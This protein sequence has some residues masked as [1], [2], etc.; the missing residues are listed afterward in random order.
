M[1]QP[2]NRPL[3]GVKLYSAFLLLAAGDSL[4]EGIWAVAWPAGLFDLLG[5]APPQ[6][7]LWRTLGVFLLAQV[8][9]LVFAAVRPLEYRSLIL[10]PLIGRTLLAGVW[11][12]LLGTDRISLPRTPLF[13]LLAHDA[14]WLPGFAA[15]L[16]ARRRG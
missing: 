2:A 10:V 9:C 12:W 6:I 3:S 13:I 15:C 8:P 11:L 4:A 5:T 7:L 1:E 14:V 16:L